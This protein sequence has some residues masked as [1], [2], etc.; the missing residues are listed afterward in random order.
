MSVVARPYALTCCVAGAQELSEYASKEYR[1]EKQM[2]K[3]QLEWK[4]VQFELAPHAGTHMLKSVDDVQQ[5]CEVSKREWLAGECCLCLPGTGKTWP[6]EK[7]RHREIA[8]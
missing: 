8:V 5:V 6:E 7:F 2:E 4:N 1:L 3:M